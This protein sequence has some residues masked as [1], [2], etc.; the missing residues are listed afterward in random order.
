M[1]N[2]K[3]FVK[4]T[5]IFG[6]ERQITD[7]KEDNIEMPL[8]QFDTESMIEYLSMKKIGLHE[9]QISEGLLQWSSN[10]GAVKLE[11]SPRMSFHIKKLSTDLEG[12]L[13]WIT[14]KVFQLNRRGAGG[15]E[16]AVANEIY[17]ELKKISEGTIDSPQKEFKH[18]D[19]LVEHLTDKL[20]RVAKP[21]F[22][23]ERVKKLSSNNYLIVFSLR[24]QGVE[25]RSHRQI[26]EVLTQV[27]F[28][29][30]QGT[31]RVMN[32]QVGNKTGRDRK[33]EIFP[34]DADM[35]FFPSQSREEIGE[36]L[37]TFFRYY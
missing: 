20:R 21:M 10:P 36:C 23:F 16:D 37:A 14:K 12:N 5:D 27:S 15:Y 34:S 17:E 33:W 29:E 28:D 30:N 2:F 25:G 35:F 6:F 26:G 11:V 31:L 7:E 18:L 9:A 32:Y 8:N 24:G 4:T 13:R 19:R 3:D 22:I 1:A